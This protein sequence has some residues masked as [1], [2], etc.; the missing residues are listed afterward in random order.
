MIIVTVI[1]FSWR[2]DEFDY[3][4]FLKQGSEKPHSNNMTSIKLQHTLR[5]N[6]R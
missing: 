6:N 1:E 4:Q 5:L 2:P 3:F